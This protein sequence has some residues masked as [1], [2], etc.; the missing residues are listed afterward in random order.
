MAVGAY[1]PTLGTVITTALIDSINPCAIGVLILLV[2]IMIAFKT[3]KEM[4]FYGLIYV[5]AVFVTYVLAGFGILYFLSSIPLYIS[6]YISIAVGSLIIIAG[7]IEIKDFF[8]YGQGITLAIPQERAK[9]IHDMTKKIT[10]PGVIFLGIFVAGVE[11]PCTGAPYLAI[12]LLLSQNFNFAAFLMLILY[13][14][15]FI[16]PLIVILLMVY[17]GFKIQ[18]IKR[19]KQNNRTYMRLATGIIL[20][21]LGWLLI[22]I[23]N[24]TITLN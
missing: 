5:L 21:F 14:I 20:I 19:W 7:L 2:S 13:N 23:A 16:L 3:K 9:Q 18:S 8:W 22:L 17:F 15:I 4:L 24:G 6:E 10:L 11:L 1:L 12:L